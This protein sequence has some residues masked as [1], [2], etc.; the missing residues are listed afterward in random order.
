[1]KSFHFSSFHMQQQQQQY[2]KFQAMQRESEKV[3]IDC[4][5]ICIGFPQLFIEFS[6]SNII[7]QNFIYHQSYFCFPEIYMIHKREK[8]AYLLFRSKLE[9][10]NTEKTLSILDANELS[11]ED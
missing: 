11:L 3:E 5:R 9:R 2:K 1:M 10:S 7:L 8:S 4:R 6:K